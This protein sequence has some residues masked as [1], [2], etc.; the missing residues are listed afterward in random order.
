MLTARTATEKLVAPR[1]DRDAARALS[2]AGALA[3]PACDARVIFKAGERRTP[4]FAHAPGATCELDADPD[5][6]NET[7][8]H[9]TLKLAL[10]EWALAQGADAELEARV[11][12]TGQRADVLVRHRGRTL[13]L[14]VQQ[15]DI[16]PAAWRAR[17]DGYRA[18]G[19]EDVWLL[20]GKPP[21]AAV[22][23][24]VERRKLP[25]SYRLELRDMQ[26]QI[27]AATGELLFAWTTPAPKAATL[28]AALDRAL[29]RKVHA[30]ASFHAAASHHERD[31]AGP[32][33]TALRPGLTLSGRHVHVAPLAS[34]TLAP[35]P[36]VIALGAAHEASHAFVAA[37]ARSP[38]TARTPGAPAR[39]AGTPPSPPPGRRRGWRA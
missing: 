32:W 14:E 19:V 16:A 13:A 8:A 29:P 36:V 4:H 22:I 15:S 28:H 7:E 33:P 11:P 9:L 31:G 26:A 12:A 3:C 30:L 2:Q 24:A 18:A 10:W 6:C 5:T 23:P 35:R 17:H 27:L 39:P 38:A 34:C 20:V 21:G 37:Q 1:V 25:A